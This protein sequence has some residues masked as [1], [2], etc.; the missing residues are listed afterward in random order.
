MDFNQQVTSALIDQIDYLQTDEFAYLSMT[1]KNELTFRDKVAF[2]LHSKLK[3]D[4]SVAR[5][6]KVSNGKKIDLAILSKDKSP[7]VFIEFK[8]ASAIKYTE[9]TEF[10]SMMIE[11][12]K[13]CAD[14]SLKD[15]LIY[16]VVITNWFEQ[17]LNFGAHKHLEQTVKYLDKINK[18]SDFNNMAEHAKQSWLHFLDNLPIKLNCLPF[19]YYGGNFAGNRVN[20]LA[21]INGPYIKDEIALLK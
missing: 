4:Y 21:L 8:A 10:H 3:D 13:K 7:K 6:H 11:D 1:S 17:Q 18:H 20:Y 5:E 16:F 2:T 15:T 14:N 12:L 9:S 19:V